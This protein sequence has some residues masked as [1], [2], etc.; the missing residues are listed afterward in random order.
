MDTYSLALLM[1]SLTS[2]DRPVVRPEVNTQY[3]VR[4]CCNTRLKIDTLILAIS[5]EAWAE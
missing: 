4:S 5:S 2:V 3:V 1:S